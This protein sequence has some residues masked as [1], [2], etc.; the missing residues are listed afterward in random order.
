MYY[1]IV[2]QQQAYDYARAVCEAISKTNLNNA[3]AL[4]IETACA[5]TQLGKYKDPTERYA[6]T[7]LTQVDESTFDW[8]KSKYDS[9]KVENDLKI[10]FGFTLSKVQYLEL[11]LSPLLA[12]VFCRLRYMTVRDPI[13]GTRIERAKYWKKNYNSSIGKG[14]VEGYLKKV[15]DCIG[16]E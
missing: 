11:D 13:P 6:G 1:G 7:G 3:I 12:F 14:T 2:K 10:A 15:S 9:S 8:L 5:E 4:L 16:D